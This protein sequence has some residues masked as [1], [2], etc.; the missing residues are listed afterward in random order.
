M[1]IERLTTIYNSYIIT[2]MNRFIFELDDESAKVLEGKKNKAQVVRNALALYNGDITTDSIQGLRHS[3]ELI[4]EEQKKT[5]QILQ[6]MA[7]ALEV[8]AHKAGSEYKLD[9]FSE[10][11]A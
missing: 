8:V 1:Y 5:N 4:L 7:E 11:G 3:Y 6:G 2:D 9:E 10:F